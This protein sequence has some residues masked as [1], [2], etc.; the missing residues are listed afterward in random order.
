MLTGFWAATLDYN[1]PTYLVHRYA[2]QHAMHDCRD[3]TG[4]LM[5]YTAS[6]DIY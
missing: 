1:L 2:T 4:E 6:Y 3:V 5:A